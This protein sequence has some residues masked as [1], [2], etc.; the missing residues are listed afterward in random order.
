MKKSRLYQNQDYIKIKI[1]SKL[2]PYPKLRLCQILRLRSRL[3]QNQD[4]INF[5]FF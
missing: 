4:Y 5:I 1:V 2:R 3:Y